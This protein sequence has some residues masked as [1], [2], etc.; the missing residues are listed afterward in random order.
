MAKCKNPKTAPA[1]SSG[2]DSRIMPKHVTPQL[3]L[4]VFTCPYCD[5]TARQMWYG[6]SHASSAHEE[7]DEKTGET[8]LS[9]FGECITDSAFSDWLFSKCEN[10]KEV[11]VWHREE[12]VHPL[13]CPVD[14]P[15]IDMPESVRSRYLE[16]SRVVALSPTSAAA[17]LRLA[18]QLLL[19]EILG[20]SSTG[21]IFKDINILKQRP[22]DSSLIKALDIIRISGNESVHPGTL[23]LAE[24]KDDA[25]YLF[26]LLNMICDQCFTQ[27]RK[28]QE[29]Y[30]R[31]PESKRIIPIEA[32]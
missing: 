20:E 23:N 22:L 15:N 21:N 3:L 28:M 12:M 13:S 8:R 17:L 25:L 9:F 29:M 11:A 31:L 7:H 4:D 32:S 16:A 5:V 6:N 19:E 18:L 30:E 14:E 10:C 26:D 2:S 27:P 24:N 1:L